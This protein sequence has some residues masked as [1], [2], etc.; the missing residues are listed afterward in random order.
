MG[1][2]DFAPLPVGTALAVTATGLITV[3]LTRVTWAYW[4]DCALAAALG[5][6]RRRRSNVFLQGVYKPVDKEEDSENLKVVGEVPHSLNGVFAR[7]GP[8]PYFTPV[9]DYHV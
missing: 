5:L 6:P 3:Y 9:G 1:I 8:N 2:L 7:V 4:V